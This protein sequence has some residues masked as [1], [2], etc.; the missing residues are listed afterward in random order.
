VDLVRDVAARRAGDVVHPGQR[1]GAGRHEQVVVREVEAL[2][3]ALT[4]PEALFEAEMAQFLTQV[5]ALPD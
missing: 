3:G 4:K 2:A 1:R 5:G